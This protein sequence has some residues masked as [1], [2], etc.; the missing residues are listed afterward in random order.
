VTNY[1]LLLT[2]S[3]T[4]LISRVKQSVVAA[5]GVTTGIAAFIILISFMNGLNGMLDGLI[6][7]RTPHIHIYN[8][9][10]PSENQPIDYYSEFENGFN[11]V[12]SIKPKQSQVRIH[13]AK[14]LL[15][16]LEKD[17]RV[18][19]ITP[20]VA[21]R[22]FYV[23]GSI[24]L[25]GVMNGINALDETRLFNFS[26]YIIKGSAINLTKNSEGILLGAGVAKKLSVTVG[27]RVQIGTINGGIHNLKIVG[28][29]QS[30][31]ADY[32]NVQSFGNLKT[33]QKLLGEGSNYF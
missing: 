31:M 3:I 15:Y 13:N 17:P 22:V 26:D 11:I 32:D 29:Y 8:D 20:Q 33:V 7:N 18:K 5:L 1:K 6:L 10:K 27:D 24:Q 21:A 23:A 14:A 12:R 30:G 4:H 2:I 19:G 16:N 9:I 25:N 28:I